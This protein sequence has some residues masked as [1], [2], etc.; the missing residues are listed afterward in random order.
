MPIRSVEVPE[1]IFKPPSSSASVFT[2]HAIA[3]VK[4]RAVSVVTAS[5]R[6][7]EWQLVL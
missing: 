6:G 5:G 2:E 3:E 7:P 4:T 1:P